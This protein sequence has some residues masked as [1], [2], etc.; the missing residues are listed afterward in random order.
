M[1]G[2]R[3]F[4]LSCSV[5]LFQTPPALHTL[6]VKLNTEYMDT[7]DFSQELKDTSFKTIVD[8][9]LEAKT[10]K[11]GLSDRLQLNDLLHLWVAWNA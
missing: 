6:Q 3:F 4:L 1:S 8:L 10:G 5:F 11:P 2:K 7:P 9:W